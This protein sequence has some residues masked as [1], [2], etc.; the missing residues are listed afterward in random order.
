MVKWKPNR[1]HVYGIIS[2][3]GEDTVMS[4]T[5][6]E[7]PDPEKTGEDVLVDESNTYMLGS[8]ITTLLF[9]NRK[10]G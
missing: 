10:E 4:E 6:I 3:Y 9:R 7:K 1:T 8:G 2:K 5:V